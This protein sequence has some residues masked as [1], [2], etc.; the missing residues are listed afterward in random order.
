MPNF[1]VKNVKSIGIVARSVSAEALTIKEHGGEDWQP[2]L[3]SI[4][5]TEFES[6]LR[7]VSRRIQPPS[8]ASSE[9]EG[10]LKASLRPHKSCAINFIIS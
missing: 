1:E 5:D 10:I 9:T 4:E 3:N 8:E 7:K 6:T 2:K